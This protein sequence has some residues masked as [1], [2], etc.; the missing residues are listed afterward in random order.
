MQHPSSWQT[1]GLMMEP[2][3]TEWFRNAFILPI[4]FIFLDQD[5]CSSLCVHSGAQSCHPGARGQGVF[6]ASQYSQVTFCG[7]AASSGSDGE[8]PTLGNGMLASI[9]IFYEIRVS[10]QGNAVSWAD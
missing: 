9:L 10:L 4:F 3:I 2:E 6:L 1:E 8:I 5:S 7:G